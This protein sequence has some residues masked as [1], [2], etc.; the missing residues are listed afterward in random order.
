MGDPKKHRKK[1]STPGHPWQRAR[2]EEERTL[3]EEYGFKNKKEIWKMNSFLRGATAQAKKLVTLS[4][5]QAEKE[6]TLLLTRLRRYGLL[7]QEAMLADILSISLRDVLERRFQTQV[8]KKGMANTMNQARQFITHEHV[9]IGG[10]VVT[11]PS[12]LIPISE[13]SQISFRNNS[14][15]NDPENPERAA[16]TK[17]KENPVEKKKKPSSE[18]SE[19]GGRD[20]GRGKGRDSGFRQKRE[21]RRPAPTQKAAGG[22]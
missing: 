19:F 11:S 20:R 16:A 4:G 5:P 12:Y 17:A 18:K 9:C 1:Y 2:I 3:M 6:K 13:E 14:K 15:L 7:S 8:Y 21:Q 10:K 22:K